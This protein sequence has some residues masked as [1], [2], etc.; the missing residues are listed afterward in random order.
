MI[1]FEAQK[2]SAQ[3]KVI[4]LFAGFFWKKNKMSGAQIW[5]LLGKDLVSF[6]ALREGF[7]RNGKAKEVNT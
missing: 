3:K 6:L 4:W 2:K 5:H 7:K 1:S